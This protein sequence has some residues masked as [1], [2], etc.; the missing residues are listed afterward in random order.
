MIRL[1]KERYVYVRS[2][3]KLL[4]VTAIATTPEE[5]NAEMER[6]SHAAVI[7]C[8][9]DLIFLADKY[10]KGERIPA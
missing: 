7:A 6:D 9:D 5:A 3:G 1:G 8:F 4:R 2:M 10:D